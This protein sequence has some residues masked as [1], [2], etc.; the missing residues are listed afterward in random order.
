MGAGV[1]IMVVLVALTSWK[2]TVEVPLE[3]FE[4]ALVK[5]A[6]MECVAA[7]GRATVQSGTVPVGVKVLVQRVAPVKVSL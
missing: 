5:A 2:R 3:K 7:V 6:V 1:S 4:F